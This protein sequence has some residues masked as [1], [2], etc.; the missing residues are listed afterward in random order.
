MWIYHDKSAL[1]GRRNLSQGSEEI[2]KV[3]VLQ[4]VVCCVSFYVP[5]TG[6]LIIFQKVDEGIHREM[7]L[8]SKF[9]WIFD[10]EKPSFP[11]IPRLAHNLTSQQLVELLFTRRQHILVIQYPFHKS[12]S[13]FASDM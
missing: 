13:M 7:K 5:N 12:H 6:L 3:A 8:L 1:C 2:L 9:P 11:E 4:L 10:V